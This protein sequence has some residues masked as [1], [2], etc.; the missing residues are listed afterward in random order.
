MTVTLV[1]HGIRGT[2]SAPGLGKDKGM[3][4]FQKARGCLCAVPSSGSYGCLVINK[5]YPTDTE[6]SLP[7]QAEILRILDEIRIRGA[8]THKVGSDNETAPYQNSLR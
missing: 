4:V 5:S 3:E 6:V 8:N 2:G 1:P 7:E